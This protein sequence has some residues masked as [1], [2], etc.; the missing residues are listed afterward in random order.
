MIEKYH[1]LLDGEK[2]L[3][4]HFKVKE[5]ASTR[6]GQIFSDIV[7]IDTEL[8]VILEKLFEILSCGMIIITSGY[9]TKEHDKIVG[10]N[11]V[12]YH[13]KGCA[14]DFKCKDK[15]G[16]FIDAKKICCALEDMGTV[17]GIGYI[18]G[19]TVHLDTRSANQ[20]WWGDETQNNRQVGSFY[21][22]FNIEKKINE[23]ITPND[24]VWEL[25]FNGIVVDK[26]GMLKEIEREPNGRLYWLARKTANYIRFLKAR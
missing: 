2:S 12:G 23:L 17:Y 4:E 25:E 20:K 13:T 7:L 8:I 11:G 15:T 22:Y 26:D 21:S 9:R 18:N 14:V 1:L 24:I 19:Y 16:S 10:G 5:F 3:S 6:A